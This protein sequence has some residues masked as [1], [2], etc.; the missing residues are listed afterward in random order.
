MHCQFF[1]I[2]A[3]ILHATLKQYLEVNQ[4]FKKNEKAFCRYVMKNDKIISILIFFLSLS[5]WG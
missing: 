3:V 4:K 1:F 5:E 2:P